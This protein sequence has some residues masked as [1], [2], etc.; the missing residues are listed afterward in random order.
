M[1]RTMKVVNINTLAKKKKKIHTLVFI[2]LADMLLFLREV[3]LIYYIVP[4]IF[5]VL[6]VISKSSSFLCQYDKE[7]SISKLSQ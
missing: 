6:C 2:N 5:I 4:S 3:A 1:R 7:R